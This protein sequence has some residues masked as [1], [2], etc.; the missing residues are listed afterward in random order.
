MHIGV[1][2]T[3]TP[4]RLFEGVTV[5]S[6]LIST[7]QDGELLK[8][9]FEHVAD[10]SVLPLPRLFYTGEFLALY[11]SDPSSERSRC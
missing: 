3:T 2:T 4:T 7:F 6:P 10:L 11:C 8:F 1:D 5:L 9:V